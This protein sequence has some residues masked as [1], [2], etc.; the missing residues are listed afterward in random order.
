MTSYYNWNP[1]LVCLVLLA[2]FVLVVEAVFR[3]NATG[4]ALEAEGGPRAGDVALILGGIV[5][6]L[7]LML[8]FTFAMG[9][10][11]YEARR[12]LVI[13]EANAIGTT[14]LRT[15]LLPEPE[16]RRLRELI[17]RY[18]A[19]R[20]AIIGQ[21]STAEEKVRR[22]D[23]AAKELHAAMWTEAVAAAR[24]SPTPVTALFLASL[25]EML[26]LHD[27]RLAAFRNRVPLIV[28]LVLFLLSFIAM[29]VLGYYFRVRGSRAR[30]LTI[31]VG[32]LI[33]SVL[34][35]IM[36]LDHPVRGA[37][38]AS[39]QSLVDLYTEIHRDRP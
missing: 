38:T 21:A 1:L 26:D 5:T 24:A 13:D 33:A 9:Q 34:W 39:Q 14:Y 29:A 11:R 32:L 2:L 28:Y 7:A 10:D 6:L 22:F 12:R 36:D 18:L 19:H 20:V 37:I 3:I 23:A 30:F 15:R 17:R 25:N 31:T 16:G 27:V 4:R 8:G 35:L